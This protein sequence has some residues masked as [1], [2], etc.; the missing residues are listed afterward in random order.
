MSENGQ[1]ANA[2]EWLEKHASIIEPAHSIV[3]KL[4]QNGFKALFAGGCVRDVIMDREPQ[5]IDI[6]TNAHPDD[7]AAL[8]EKTVP[9]GASFGVMK[10]IIETIR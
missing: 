5:D 2:K 10:V 1:H 8:F 7:V 3:R 9:V 4:A 6:A